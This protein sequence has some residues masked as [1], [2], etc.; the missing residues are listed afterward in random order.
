KALQEETGETVILGRQ[1]GAN[2]Q[3]I[4]VLLADQGLQLT[5][6]VGA[7]RPM[8]ITGLGQVLLA[9]KPL[10]DVN[11]IVRRNNAEMPKAWR[12]NEREFLGLLEKVRARGYAFATGSLPLEQ[13]RSPCFSPL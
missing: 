8:T 1:N 12:V 5:A 10:K 7:L 11:L 3:Y 9:A 4:S 13:P 2:V 6:Q